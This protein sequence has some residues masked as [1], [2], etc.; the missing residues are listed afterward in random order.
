MN[1]VIYSST[2]ELYWYP[3]RPHTKKRV[4]PLES[5][6]RHHRTCRLCA[7]QLA[8]A[9]STPSERR[10]HPDAERV[11]QVNNIVSAI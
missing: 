1:Q 3:D 10:R 6:H 5:I 9:V 4:T 8:D 2:T 7:Q 11:Q